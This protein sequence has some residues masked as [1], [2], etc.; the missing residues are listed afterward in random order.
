MF[1]IIIWNFH[2][3]RKVMNLLL[4]LHPFTEYAEAG[5]SIASLH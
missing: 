5:L 3:K 1:D 4:Q 2:V